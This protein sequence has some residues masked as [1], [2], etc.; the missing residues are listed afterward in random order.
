M[1][2]MNLNVRKGFN[3]GTK[4][5]TIKVPPELREKHSTG[6]D[7]IDDIMGGEGGFTRTS[8]VML[9]GGPGCGKSTLV[10]QLANAMAGTG[11]L[12]PVYNTGEESLY[13]AKM[14]CERL[15]LG[16]DFMVGEETDLPKLLAFMDSVR[17]GNKGKVPVFL[18]DS[19]QT[20]NDMKYK[21]GGTTGNTPVRCTEMLVDWTQRSFGHTW[22]IGQV[23]K[24]GDFA[25]K[26]T[27]KHAVDVHMHLFYDE[28]KKSATNGCLLAEVQK[29]RWG[30]N[31]KT[32][33]LGL[34]ATGIEE[35]GSFEKVKGRVIGD[36]DEVAA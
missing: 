15:K 26:N 14:A 3:L 7:W 31:G 33:I 12:L 5:S 4:V 10:R 25:G 8:T 28:D 36:E 22:F 21:D 32:Y 34:T 17:A 29:N 16:N 20:L 23:T 11:Q 9:T 6:L 19:V 2:A 27:I 24:S 30:C 18:Q 35:R 13:Q 1:A